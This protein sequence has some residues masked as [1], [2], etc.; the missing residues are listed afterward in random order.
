MIAGKGAITWHNTSISDIVK[1]TNTT[2][3]KDDDCYEKLG[4][5][6]T[7]GGESC[8]RDVTSTSLTIHIEVVGY[9]C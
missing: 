5:S 8:D 4:W 6:C 9:Y 7:L 3:K 2:K 1:F